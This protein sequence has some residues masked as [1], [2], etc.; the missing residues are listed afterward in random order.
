MVCR[1]YRLTGCLDNLSYFPLLVLLASLIGGCEC[2]RVNMDGE[3]SGRATP[4]SYKH[5]GLGI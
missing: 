4:G 2:T 1:L 3:V 5:T